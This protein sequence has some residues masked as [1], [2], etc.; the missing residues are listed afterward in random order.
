MARAITYGV[1]ALLGLFVLTTTF[2][3]DKGGGSARPA[4]TDARIT[5]HDLSLEPEAH[6]GDTVTTEGDLLFS[7]DIK[8]WQVVDEGIAIVIVG[9][10]DEA[11]RGLEGR[12]VSV[13][14]RFD[15]DLGTGIF[16]DAEQVSE[17]N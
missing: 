14:G 12:R 8:Q 11:F 7:A 10:D 3:I 17:V 13:T 2:L 5:V 9:Y 16:I 6:R 15:F 4:D 1:I